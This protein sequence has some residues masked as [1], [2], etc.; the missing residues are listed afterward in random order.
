MSIYFITITWQEDS[1][2]ENISLAKTIV[3]GQKYLHL[4]LTLYMQVFTCQIF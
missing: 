1:G 4:R 2:D 3:S